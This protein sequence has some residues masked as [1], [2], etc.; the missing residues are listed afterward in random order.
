MDSKVEELEEQFEQTHGEFAQNTDG[1]V[2]AYDQL[3]S[4][5]DEMRKEIASKTRQ[6]NRLQREIQRFQL[7]AKQEEA[8][9]NDRHREL[10]ARKS[11]G[12]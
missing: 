3:K 11:R 9:I 12:T 10:L 1:T 7:I 5:D 4:K 2:A 8:Q 6:A